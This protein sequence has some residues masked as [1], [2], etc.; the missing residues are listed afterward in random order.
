ME[1][2]TCE[3]RG[4]GGVQDC[5]CRP[6]QWLTLILIFMSISFYININHY[7]CCFGL[8]GQ[9]ENDLPLPDVGRDTE[10]PSL[11][12]GL[13]TFAHLKSVDLFIVVPN[14]ERQIHGARRSLG[15]QQNQKKKE[16]RSSETDACG[17][18][19]HTLSPG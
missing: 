2:N 18:R 11:S 1:G 9:W 8:P 15:E 14:S 19:G 6:E 7:F 4:G 3:K 13:Q 10:S 5:S 16:G 17:E 12:P